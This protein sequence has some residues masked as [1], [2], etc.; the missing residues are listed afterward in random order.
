MHPARDFS[1]RQISA[2]SAIGGFLFGYDTGI[3][4]GAMVFI[5][6]DFRLSDTWQEVIISVTILGALIFSMISGYLADKFGRKK[7]IYVASATFAIGS[8]VMGFAIDRY[9]LMVGRFIV[10]AAIGFASMV[11]P[12]YIAEVSPAHARGSLVTLNTVFVT[13]GQAIAA[14]FAGILS[15]VPHGWRYMLGAAAIPAIIQF[16]GFL[17]MPESPRWLIRNN[18]EDMA[19]KALQSIR[20]DSENVAEEFESMRDSCKDSD[21]EDRSFLSVISDVISDKNLRKAL[22][23]GFCPASYSTAYWRKYCDVL[24]SYNYSDVWNIRQDNCSVAVISHGHGQFSRHLYSHLP[25]GQSR[26]P[27]L[28]FGQ[29]DRCHRKLGPSSHRLPSKHVRRSWSFVQFESPSDSDCTAFSDCNGCTGSSQCGFCFEDLPSGTVNG[30]C[31]AA[32]TSHPAFQSDKGLCINGTDN[33]QRTVWAKDWCP[34]PYSWSTML[35]LC[36][37][38][39]CFSPGMGPMPWTINSEIYPQWARSVC[40]S[41]TTAINWFFNMMVSLTFLTLTRTITIHGAFYL[42]SAFGVAGFLYL[43]VSLPETKGQS[44]DNTAKLFNNQKS[45][46]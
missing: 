3:I 42:Y 27:S 33:N 30:S 31:I 7:V 26:S 39:L 12:M 14:V 4:S 16:I 11:V 21:L 34:S 20:G 32:D 22:L 28:D 38:L 37:Y 46:K 25:G 10:G 23:L 18:K 9:T 13:G 17:F 1:S 5:K 19:R 6:D 8:L 36:I 24:F 35:G 2:L 41:T 43:Y 44:L 40:L 45:E 29:F 15:T